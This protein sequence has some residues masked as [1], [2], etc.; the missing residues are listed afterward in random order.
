MPAYIIA[1]IEVH[2]PERYRAYTARTPDVLA[3]HDGRFIVRGGAVTTLEGE[4]ETRRVVVLEFPDRA[5][6]EAFYRSDAYQAAKA[7]RAGAAT[8]RFIVVDGV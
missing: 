2:D 8:A 7:L 5:R 3:A 6:A 1:Q 4:A